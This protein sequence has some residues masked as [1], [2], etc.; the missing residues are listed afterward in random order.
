[1]PNVSSE[2][3]RGLPLLLSAAVALIAAGWLAGDSGVPI[4]AAALGGAGLVTLGAWIGSSVYRAGR[5]DVPG[6]EQDH[7]SM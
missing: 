2:W 7:A 4:A 3:L 1:M 5:L 6:E